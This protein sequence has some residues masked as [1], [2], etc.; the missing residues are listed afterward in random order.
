MTQPFR[1]D[2]LDRLTALVVTTLTKCGQARVCQDGRVQTVA[3]DRRGLTP[4]GMF[5]LKIDT[6]R[7]PHGVFVENLVSARIRHQLA[8]V[9]HHPVDVLNT[10]GVTYVIHLGETR[11]RPALPDRARLADVLPQHP[12]GLALP[13]GQGPD[14]PVWKRL[15]SHL[16]VGGETGAGKTTWLKSTLAALAAV[17]R[18]ET[19]QVVIVDPKA[20]D[21]L[22]FAGLPHLARPIA[23][24]PQEAEEVVAW[25]AGQVDERRRRFLSAPAGDIEKYNAQAR[26]KLAYLVAI[27]DEITTLVDLTGGKKGSVHQ[28]LKRL[29]GL[30]RSFGIYLVLATQNPKADILDTH[31]RGNLALRIAFRVSTAEHSRVILGTAGAEKLPAVK[32]RLLARLGGGSLQEL[33]GYTVTDEELAALGVVGNAD[34]LSAPV[35]AL[36]TYAVAHLAGR[37]PERELCQE[38][39]VSKAE[40]RRARDQLLTAGYLGRGDNN[41]LIIIRRPDA[42]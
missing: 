24:D 2:D 18:P 4:S 6:E 10:T 41:A 33:Q 14:G 8:A 30:A 25:L 20:V 7:L 12:G 22:P 29:A 19:V 3:I 28:Q 16:L 26:E 13:V 27:V 42:A 39:Q 5:L 32:G 36:L 11:R 23:G 9:T 15:D 37:F 34:F 1:D 38:M 31:L 21:F 40:Y 17:N 35:R